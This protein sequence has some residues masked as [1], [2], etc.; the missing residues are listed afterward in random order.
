LL[1]NSLVTLQS[2]Q[3]GIEAVGFGGKDEFMKAVSYFVLSK[4]AEYRHLSNGVELFIIA[5]RDSDTYDG[6][7]ISA[8][9]R[10]LVD[11]IKKLIGEQEFQRVHVMFA[12]QAI[13]TWLL[14]DEQKLNECLGVTNKVKHENEPEKIDNPKLVVQ[15]LFVQYGRRYTP[16]QLLDLLPQL[17]VAELRRCKHFKEFYDCV[18]TIA[19]MPQ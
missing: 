9:R 5:L 3:V 7:R 2:D 15:N 8:L 14:A 1:K 13:E 10:K 6:K 17:R 19:E 12:V 4:F 16:L 18:R 11:K